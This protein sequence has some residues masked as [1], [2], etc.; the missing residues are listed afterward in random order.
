MCQFYVHYS[1][2]DVTLESEDEVFFES[3]DSDF[4]SYEVYSLCACVLFAYSCH[5]Q[6]LK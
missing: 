3:D 6:C 1:I 5:I 2:D 4:K